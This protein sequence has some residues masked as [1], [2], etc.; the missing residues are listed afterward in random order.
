MAED[1]LPTITCSK[2]GH[3]S[4]KRVAKPIKC[5]SCGAQYKYEEKPK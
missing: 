2:C 5:P 3:V 4:V 1:A